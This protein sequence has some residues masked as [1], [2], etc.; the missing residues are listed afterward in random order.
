MGRRVE[1]HKVGKVGKVGAFILLARALI[2]VQS[3][4]YLGINSG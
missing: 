1:E 3:V 4:K 2:K